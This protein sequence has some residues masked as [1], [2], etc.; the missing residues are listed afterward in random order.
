VGGVTGW[1]PP[2]VPFGR[3]ALVS[4][5]AEAAVDLSVTGRVKPLRGVL[6][7]S[8]LL[9]YRFN[10]SDMERVAVLSGERVPSLSILARSFLL[11][12]ATDW[13]IAVLQS[14]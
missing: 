4:D 1:G 13:S 12:L 5:L 9:R 14:L 3:R 6:A 8:D 10:D 7:A 11:R 2:P